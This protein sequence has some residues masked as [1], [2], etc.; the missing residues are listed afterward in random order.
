MHPGAAV[1]GETAVTVAIREP[2]DPATG[3]F[4]DAIVPRELGEVP[5][6]EELLGAP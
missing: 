4:E 6:L 3:E 1:D 5:N 2:G